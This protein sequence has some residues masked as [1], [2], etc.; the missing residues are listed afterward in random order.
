MS[1][2]IHRGPQAS[3]SS[4][5]SRR[6]HRRSV[7]RP[8]VFGLSVLG[9]ALATLALSA[10]SAFGLSKTVLT[11][12]FAGSGANAISGPTDVAVDESTDPSRGDLY[13]TDP[14]HP[15]VQTLTLNAT[16][17]TYSLS[18]EGQTT[19]ARG[20]GNT[21]FAEGTGD[22]TEGSETVENLHAIGGSFTV[23]SPISGRGVPEGTTITTIGS[24]TLSLSNPATESGT[25][26]ELRVS[27]KVV[28]HL[29]TSAGTFLAGE[30]VSGPG[31]PSGAIITEVGAETLTLSRPAGAQETGTS[32]SAALPFNA[33]A[34]TIE[35]ALSGLSPIGEGNIRV[36]GEGPYTITFLGVFAEEVVPQITVDSSGLSGGNP[37]SIG[38]IATTDTGAGGRVEKFTPSG[39]FVLMLGKEVNKTTVENHAPVA[40]Q[41]I[42]TAESGDTCQAA[43]SGSTPGAFKAPT[44]IAVDDSSSSSMGDFYVGDTGDNTISKFN[45]SGDLVGSWGTGGQSTVSGLN[46]IAVDSGGDLFVLDE[47]KDTVH[48]FSSRGTSIR[49]FDDPN[50]HETAPF[51]LVVDAEDHLFKIDQRYGVNPVTKFNSAFGETLGE[52]T[53]FDREITGLAIAPSTDELYVVEGGGDVSLYGPGCSSRCSP[54]ETFGTGSL[55]GARGLALNA[56]GT[57]YV[58]DTG[59]NRIAVFNSV[60]VPELTVRSSAITQTSVKLIG[61]I[62][63]AGGGPVIS[64]QFDYGTSG[65]YGESVPCSPDPS[66]SHF[67]G[68][69]EV[70]AELS[71]LSPQTTYHFRLVAANENG[72]TLSADQTFL[73][74]TPPSV[75]AESVGEVEADSASVQ[76]EVNPGGG[77]G[78]F[79]VEYV[80]QKAFEHG[81][82]AAAKRSASLNTGSTDSL[83]GIRSLLTGLEPGT[84][85]HYRVVATNFLE[86]TQGSD[87]TFTTLPFIPSVNDQCPNAHVRQQTGAAQLLDCRAYELVSAQTGGYDVESE[88][89]RGPDS[90]RRLP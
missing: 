21:A 24:G 9:F 29:H 69:T 81:E 36:G 68:P 35:N 51:G 39:E 89:D 74:P 31:I 30:A 7:A 71:G 65:E 82:F 28:S 6:S 54:S 61:H 2:R 8:T 32:L 5:S 72:S 52:P 77:E 46:G 78:S 25:S 10:A 33:E 70:T 3:E 49:E 75:S 80:T 88:S 42:C 15:D 47:E 37:N 90:I 48:V 41:D 20:S 83:Q 38:T 17:G 18:F 85:Y 19:G 4:S 57:V 73:I 62:D 44:F 50:P 87:R 60:L 16:G 12:T 23:G 27:S 58:A 45:S 67:S 11:N 56:A 59:G 26:V 86:T 43:A 66:S 34:A 1:G 13:V 40:E 79:V 64:C 53:G 84:T 63:P 22:L 76:A 55:S 14:G